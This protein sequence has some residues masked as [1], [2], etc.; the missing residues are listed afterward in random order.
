MIKYG[1]NNS[2]YNVDWQKYY[3]RGSQHNGKEY[4]NL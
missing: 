4:G 2:I 3:G 1:Y